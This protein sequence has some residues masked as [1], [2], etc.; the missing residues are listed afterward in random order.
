MLIFHSASLLRDK[1]VSIPIFWFNDISFFHP[2]MLFFAR[3]LPLAG[4]PNV[5]RL[6]NASDRDYD[7]EGG[8][9]RGGFSKEV[10]ALL[11]RCGGSGGAGSS[12]LLGEGGKAVRLPA[13]LRADS[14]AKFGLNQFDVVISDLISVNR[15]LPDVRHDS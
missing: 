14:K 9:E 15:S 12:S 1:A 3:F 11:N 8:L 5:R 10:A 6:M 4:D 13:N 2:I 7:G